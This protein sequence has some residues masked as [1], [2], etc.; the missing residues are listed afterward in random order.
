MTK[1]VVTSQ[2]TPQYRPYFTG[3]DSRGR[4][5]Q[6][7]RKIKHQYDV[8]LQ[9]DRLSIDA[10]VK[11]RTGSDRK[12]LFGPNVKAQYT[13]AKKQIIKNGKI[14]QRAK[15]GT[16]IRDD[17]NVLRGRNGDFFFRLEWV[18]QENGALFGR[19]WAGWPPVKTNPHKI[20]YLDKHAL[21]VVLTLIKKGKIKL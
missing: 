18:L 13:P 14:V 7:Q 9:L 10:P 6:F 17:L 20:P 16:L 8:T 12:M 5:R 3:K 1:F 11:Y 15:P 19:N 2:S 4:P 21:T